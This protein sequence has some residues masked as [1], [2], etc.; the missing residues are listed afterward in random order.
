MNRPPLEQFKKGPRCCLN[1]GGGGGGG[2]LRFASRG[3]L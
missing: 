3:T 1:R 2:L